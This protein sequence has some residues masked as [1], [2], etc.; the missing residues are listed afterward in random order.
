MGSLI[1]LRVAGLS[2]RQFDPRGVV[3]VRAMR[4]LRVAGLTGLPTRGRQNEAPF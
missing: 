3:Q 1:S 2:K 4:R